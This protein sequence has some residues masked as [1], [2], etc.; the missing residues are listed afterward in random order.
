MI[1]S[2]FGQYARVLVDMDISQPLRYK[3]L[4]ERK[5]FAFF[6][7]L[8]YENVPNLC[9]HYKKIGHY[10]EICKNRTVEMEQGDGHPDKESGKLNKKENVS[11]K[12]VAKEQG[13]NVEKPI[14]VEE[15]RNLNKSNVICDAPQLGEASGVMAQEVLVHN[16]KF[17]VLVEK[18]NDQIQMLKAAMKEKDIENELNDELSNIN[19]NG[20][21]QATQVR[22]QSDDESSAQNTEFFDETQQGVNTDDESTNTNIEQ[23]DDSEIRRNSELQNR[24]FLQQSWANIAENEEAEQRLLQHLESEHPKDHNAFTLVTKSKSKAS[25]L[26]TTVKINYAT[27]KINWCAK[28]F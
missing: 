25:K 10:C 17:V 12:Y 26:K 20:G 7:E 21:K 2:T 28:A 8:D 19:N 18:D 24:V 23:E 6:V 15:T 22:T 27:R 5:C 9:T 16:N 14:I 11:K 3:V 1:E 4:V 13:K